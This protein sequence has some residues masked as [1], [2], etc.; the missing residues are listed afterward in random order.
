MDN[1]SAV[2]RVT[3]SRSASVSYSVIVSNIYTMRWY[4]K[5]AKDATNQIMRDF[6]LRNGGDFLTPEAV[7][8][9]NR[10]TYFATHLPV[11]YWTGTFTGA[12][13]LAVP[14]GTGIFLNA[15]TGQHAL[16][17]RLFPQVWQ[18]GNCHS[19]AANYEHR[20]TRG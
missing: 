19:V 3:D 10:T 4:F 13:G 12:A 17:R 2:I 7:A 20:R 11:Y 14:P 1:G 8:D 15:S 18:H 6:V 16:G 5:D 9:I